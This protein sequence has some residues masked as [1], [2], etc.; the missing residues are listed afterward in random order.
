M[1]V[2]DG[3]ILISVTNSVV[4]IHVTVAVGFSDQKE[5][6]LLMNSQ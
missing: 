2:P 1:C 5:W 6:R 3:V 4:S